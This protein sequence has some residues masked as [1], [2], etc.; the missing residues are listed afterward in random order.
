MMAGTRTGQVKRLLA[1]I[2]KHETAKADMLLSDDFIFSGPTPEP[3]SKKSF[4]ELHTALVS[5][6]PDWSFDAHSFK[7]SG[8]TVEVKVNIAGTHM[9]ELNIPFLGLS[10]VPATNKEFLLPEEMIEIGFTGD[11]IS[12]F[13]V[14]KTSGGGMPGMLSQLGIKM[15]VLSHV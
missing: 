1:H 8:D 4:M 2:E 5:A 13:K 10:S 15:P 11:K 12:S 6:I 9:N 14:G 3:I 7:E